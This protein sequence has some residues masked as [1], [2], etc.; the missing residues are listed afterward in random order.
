MPAGGYH[1]ELTTGRRN[2]NY[3][4]EGLHL[5]PYTAQGTPWPQRS[6]PYVP[7]QHRL[8]EPVLKKAEVPYDRCPAPV[9][10][11]NV[12]DLDTYGVPPGGMHPPQGMGQQ[13]R[14]GWTGPLWPCPLATCPGRPGLW[15]NL[16]FPPRRSPPRSRS[17]QLDPG[18]GP[19]GY[20]SCPSSLSASCSAPF[21]EVDY[22]PASFLYNALG[23]GER[24]PE[25]FL[26]PLLSEGTPWC[27]YHALLLQ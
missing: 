8:L 2:P 22:H 11:F 12:Q 17:L 19:N 20:G 13:P 26:P 15:K 24:E 10:G 14:P 9:S 21:Q 5:Y 18:P 27:H 7:C 1:R 16:V 23:R 6:P 3:A 25:V 4:Q